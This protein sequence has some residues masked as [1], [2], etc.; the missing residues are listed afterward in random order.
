[1]SLI[2]RFFEPVNGMEKCNRKEYQHLKHYHKSFT[3]LSEIN[4]QSIYVIDYYKK[5]FNYVSPHPL[6][7]CGYEVEQVK[8]W[9]FEYFEKVVP[10]E[11]LIMA[12]EISDSGFRFFYELPLEA[13]TRC[14]LS[15]DFRLKRPDGKMILVNHC[16]Y[17]FQL[18]PNGDMWLA[19]CV[20]TLSTKQHPGN[21]VITM[22]DKPFKYKYSFESKKFRL[23]EIARL[24]DREKDV[25]RYMIAGYTEVQTAVELFVDINTV[26]Y[27]KRNIFEKTGAKNNKQAISMAGGQE[28]V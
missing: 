27:H 4:N 5:T 9:G 17:P 11:D 18:T 13:R 22:L 6:F 21:V 19:L 24:S 15:Y 3:V 16:V 14:Y 12:L 7:L 1:M 25:F 20:V 28:I 23:L 10:P 8:N 2:H 26:K